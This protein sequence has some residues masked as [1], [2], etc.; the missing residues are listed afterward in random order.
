MVAVVRMNPPVPVPDWLASNEKWK[1]QE[2]EDR[3]TAAGT[4]CRTVERDDRWRCNICGKDHDPSEVEHV[5]GK[6]KESKA[7]CPDCCPAC[8]KRAGLPPKEVPPPPPEPTEQEIRERYI[9]RSLA[10]DRGIFAGALETTRS[11]FRHYPE[12]VTAP[13]FPEPHF[14]AYRAYYGSDPSDE[15]LDVD[16]VLD[17]DYMADVHTK[18]EEF[19]REHVAR[20]LAKEVTA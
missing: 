11:M 4:Y 1:Q 10:E 5:A 9:E 6:G 14:S 19:A 17:P 20:R 2:A 18:A 3:A 7:C 8:R 15:G 12:L 16:D 13:E